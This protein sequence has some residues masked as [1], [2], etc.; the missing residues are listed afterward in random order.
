MNKIILLTI[1]VFGITFV[2]VTAAEA[3]ILDIDV[4]PGDLKKIDDSEY[5]ASAVSVLRNS[6]GQLVS[7]IKTT[8]TRYLDKPVT[9]EFIDT[10]PVIKKG[11]L[12]GKNLEMTQVAIDY[13]YAKCLT[14]L[15][16]VP[17]YTE[18]CL[19]LIHI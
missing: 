12:N 19:S 15:Y 16:D 14:E 9:D 7:V 8:A 11:T 6:D 13:D 5:K 18:Q 3:Q 10:L 4:H 17:G 2:F 1:L